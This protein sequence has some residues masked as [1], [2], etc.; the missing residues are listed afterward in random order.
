MFLGEPARHQEK[1]DN[2]KS[3]RQAD[4]DADRAKRR[5]KTQRHADWRADRPIAGSAMIRGTRELCRPRSILASVAWLA[6]KI[7]KIAATRNSA[8]GDPHSRGIGGR[9]DVDERRNE[10]A[11]RGDYRCPRHDGEDDGDAEGRPAGACNGR[12]IA[13]AISVPD[14]HRCRL[15][16]AQRDH[17]GEPRNLQRNRMPLQRRGADESHD[18]G[19]R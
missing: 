5:R 9:V 11:R 10:E 19:R 1:G 12:R 13:R 14:P 18:E 15:S 6:S 7:W 4:P 16:E 8:T 2:R 17:E 3:A